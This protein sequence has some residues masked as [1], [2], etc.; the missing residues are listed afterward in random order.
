MTMTKP[1]SSNGGSRYEVLLLDLDNTLYDWVAFYAGSLWAMISALSERL[2]IDT[3]ELTDQFRHLYEREGSVEYAFVVQQLDAT[4]EMPSE[5][6]E[7]LI[8]LAQ[9]T[10]ALARR[11][12]L[13]PYAGVPETLEAAKGAGIAVVGVTNAPLFQ[14]HRRLCQL[15]LLEYFDALAAWEG[16]HIP[17]DDPYLDTIRR[18]SARG[19]YEPRIPYVNGFERQALKPGSAMFKWALAKLGAPAQRSLAVGDS[20]EKDLAPAQALGAA[21]AWCAY[22]ASPAPADFETLLKVTPWKAEEIRRTYAAGAGEG[23]ATLD[24]FEDVLDLLEIDEARSSV[25]EVHRS[26]G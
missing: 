1:R 26:G 11:R 18:R 21:G 22:G 4:R 9:Q 8:D 14:A 17:A 13:R 5:D 7:E 15:G 12:F 10:F 6:V 19:E 24:R 23:Y 16:F 2:G 25:A 3:E 20:I